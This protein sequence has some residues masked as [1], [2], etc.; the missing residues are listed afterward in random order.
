MHWLITCQ[1]KMHVCLSIMLTYANKHRNSI[2]IKVVPSFFITLQHPSR[3]LYSLTG[4]SSYRK[5][6]NLEA[7]IFGFRTFQSLWKLTG[8]LAAALPRCLSNYWAIRS[9]YH[10]ISRPRD[11]TRFGGKTSH[12][13]ANRGPGYVVCGCLTECCISQSYAFRG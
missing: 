12:H 1:F 10:A 2:G 6:W 13:L 11:F 5:I 7:M 3:D 9:L 8:I 4:R